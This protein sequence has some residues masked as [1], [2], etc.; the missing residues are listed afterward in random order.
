VEFMK[1]LSSRFC[2]SCVIAGTLLCL[3]LFA[4]LHLLRPDYNPLRRFMSEYLVGPFGFLGTAAAYL[5]ATT[6]FMLLVGLWR[7]VRRCGF[8]TAS[9]VLLGVMVISVCVCAIFPI[10]VLRPDGS[11]STFTRAC[12]IHLA[13]SA[14]LYV[15]LVALL[16]ILPSAY[17]RDERWRSFSHVTLFFGFLTVASLVE[18]V[19]VPVYLRGLAQRENFLLI[20]VWLLLTGLR[21]RQVITLPPNTALEPTATAP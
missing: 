16:L 2:G 9:C 15:S 3:F 8:L 11:H 20:L 17:R 4:M 7:S 14:V 1:A 18:L 10:D 19:F 6:L 13:S 5:L 21:L 12:I